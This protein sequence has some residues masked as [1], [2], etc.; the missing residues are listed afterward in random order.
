M[1]S[2]ARFVW[3]LP[4]ARPLLARR[5]ILEGVL[6]D[7]CSDDLHPTRGMLGDTYLVVGTYAAAVIIDAYKAGKL[8]LKNEG[9][10]GSTTRA[11][12]YAASP[13]R[14]GQFAIDTDEVS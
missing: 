8:P 12:R 1:V 13:L 7:A 14:V 9:R 4:D 10:I 2:V 5:M 6:N 11:E 3:W